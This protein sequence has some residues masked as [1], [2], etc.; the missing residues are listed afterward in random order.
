[1]SLDV[2]LLA[3]L[4]GA[5]ARGAPT[6]PWCLPETELEGYCRSRRLD[7]EAPLINL[8]RRQHGNHK[9]QSAA[10]QYPKIWRRRR[11]SRICV[12]VSSLQT[13]MPVKMKIHVA[14]AYSTAGYATPMAPA[15]SA[16][17]AQKAR[18]SASSILRA[19]SALVGGGRII[20][21]RPSDKGQKYLTCSQS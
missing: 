20:V 8:F 7:G 11:S 6:S 19:S 5:A 18:K 17:T 21:C 9:C 16:C 1:M 4:C 15:Q 10:Q 2:L 3:C 13:T 12:S 14:S